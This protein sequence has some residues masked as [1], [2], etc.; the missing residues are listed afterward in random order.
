[1]IPRKLF[2]PLLIWAMIFGGS[3]VG[4]ICERSSRK[5]EDFDF[6]ITPGGEEN[7]EELPGDETTEDRRN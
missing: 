4:C 7:A 1:M 3:I 6:D 5:L 2:R